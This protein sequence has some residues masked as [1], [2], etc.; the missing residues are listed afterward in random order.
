[1]HSYYKFLQT[2]IF[3]RKKKLSFFLRRLSFEGICSMN[4]WPSETSKIFSLVCGLSTNGFCVTKGRFSLN[5]KVVDVFNME[6]AKLNMFRTCQKILEPDFRK[7]NFKKKC[8]NHKG[9][10]HDLNARSNFEIL[11]N[12][13]PIHSE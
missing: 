8:Q 2:I 12:W 5:M 11:L 13:L 3:S 4:A 6:I 10:V 1:M 9:G 7:C